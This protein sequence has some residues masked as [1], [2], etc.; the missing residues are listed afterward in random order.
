MLINR[1][2][3]AAYSA[4]ARAASADGGISMRTTDAAW[5]WRLKV[6]ADGGGNPLMQL[7]HPADTSGNGQTTFEAL[8]VGAS[9]MLKFYTA[10]VERLRISSA[11]VPRLSALPTYADNAAAVAGGLAVG[12]L[13][14]TATGELRVRV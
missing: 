3:Y 12:D 5:L 7:I 10:G 11:G 9:Q 8:G 2:D 6:G 14:K 13:Y 4:V 1:G